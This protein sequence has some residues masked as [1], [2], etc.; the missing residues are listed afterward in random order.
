MTKKAPEGYV[1]KDGHLVTVADAVLMES[2]LRLFGTS[3][4]QTLGC[5]YARR[6]PPSELMVRT[7]AAVGELI[8]SEETRNG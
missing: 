4:M 8:K 6:I 2:D 5:G 1:E 7:A 3:Y